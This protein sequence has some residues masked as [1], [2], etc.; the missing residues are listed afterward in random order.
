MEVILSQD[1][2]SLGKVGDVVKVKDG[3]ARNLLIPRKLAFVASAANLKRIESQKKK[4]ETLSNGSC[5]SL[6]PSDFKWKLPQSPR[7]SLPPSLALKPPS[8]P[9]KFLSPFEIK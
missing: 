2:K 5:G 6:T 4:R 9:W 1:V 3:Y 8:T 7:S